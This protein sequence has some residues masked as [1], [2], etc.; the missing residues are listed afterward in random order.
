[1]ERKL[2]V[3]QD[4]LTEKHKK[5]ILEA[6]EKGG[7]K[8]EFYD[9]HHDGI[10][11]VAGAEIVYCARNY[12]AKEAVNAK[13]IACSAAGVAPLLEPG[14]LP[15]GCILTKGAGSYGVAISEYVI[16]MTIMLLKRFPVYFEAMS[17]KAWRQGLKI[18]SIYGSCI[19]IVGTGDIGQNVASRM[20]GLLASRVIGIN[21]SGKDPVEKLFDEIYR[22]TE[23]D[24]V[25][26]DTDILVL[27]AP[28][29]PETQ[30]M[31]SGERLALLHEHAVLVNVGRGNIIDSAA[32]VEALNNDKLRG[33]AL[34]VFV[35]EPLP[36]DDPLWTAKN[37]VLTPHIAGH[38]T[39]QHTADHAVEL[40]CENLENY[41]AGRP[42]NH[43][44]DPVRGY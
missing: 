40:F 19:T 34:D 41:I 8:V 16:C 39:L 20:K 38:M 43:V 5:Q 22:F 3:V 1:M 21:Y 24:K 9:S 7:F 29:T 37:C 23:I 28:D 14:I 26:P 35:K 11:H 32:L 25:L 36:A 13:W 4:F 15:E 17:K 44:A 31:I 42:L 33:A 6:A 2:V 27:C 30:G 10:G 18:G 12:I